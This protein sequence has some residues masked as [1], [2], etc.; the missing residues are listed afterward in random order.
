LVMQSPGF[1]GVELRVTV[2]VELRVTC[3]NGRVRYPLPRIPVTLS[4]HVCA[5]V[6]NCPLR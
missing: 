3:P 5:A 4:V 1:V 2:S 6:P